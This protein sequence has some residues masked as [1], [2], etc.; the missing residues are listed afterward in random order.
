MTP[1]GALTTLI[2][3]DGANGSIPY[4]GLVQASDGQFYGTTSR[5]GN[6]DNGTVFRLTLPPPLRVSAFAISGGNA[7]LTWNTISGKTYQVQYK[8]SL[9]DAAWTNLGSPIAATGDSISISDPV[10]QNT[11]RFYRIVQVD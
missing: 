3:F 6:S 8:A 10:A 9:S 2:S 7:E 4:A 1:S 11:Q 5:G